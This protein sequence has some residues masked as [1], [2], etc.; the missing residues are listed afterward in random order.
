MKAID[1]KDVLEEIAD[2][3]AFGGLGASSKGFRV[4]RLPDGSLVVDYQEADAIFV[5][6]VLERART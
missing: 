1:R 6:S 3:L 4:D 2:A 5:V